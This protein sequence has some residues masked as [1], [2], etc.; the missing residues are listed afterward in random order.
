MS[1]GSAIGAIVSLK[2]N[3]RERTAKTEKYVK[4][5]GSKIH[6]V[7]SHRTPSKGELEEIKATMQAAN[8][9]RQLRILLLTTALLTVLGIIFFSF[10]F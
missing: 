1:F 2:N 9:K 5:T 7:V 6:R 8:R 3:R 4:T 10:M